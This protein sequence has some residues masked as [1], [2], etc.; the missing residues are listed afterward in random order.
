MTNKGGSSLRGLVAIAGALALLAT[1]TCGPDPVYQRCIT[2]RK[3][4]CSR[5][6][7]CVQLGTLI[8]VTV[9]Y[10]NESKCETQESTKCDT[11]SSS[12]PCPGGSSSSYSSA[13]HDQC[14][15]DQGNQDCS[16]FARRPTSC[17]TYCTTTA[18]DGG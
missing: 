8:G 17:Q 6:F 13:K 5:L 2:E 3:T 9:N 12:H 14:I 4:Y 11:V 16:A 15:Q 1:T 18:A 7:V 10:E